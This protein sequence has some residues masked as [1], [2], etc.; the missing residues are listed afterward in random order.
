MLLMM[1]FSLTGASDRILGGRLGYGGAFEEGFRAMGTIALTIASVYAAS[2]LIGR[3]ISP[4]ASFLLAPFGI[5]S[6]ILPGLLLSSDMGAYTLALNMTEN[7]AA[8]A[9]SGLI[10]GGTVG[11]VWLFSIPVAFSIVEKDDAEYLVTGLLCGLVTLPLASLTGGLMMAFTPYRIG[12]SEI[13]S[14]TVPVAIISL[15][16]ALALHFIPG[17]AVC[18]FRFSAKLVTALLTLFLALAAFEE[19]TGIMLPA[20]SVMALKDEAGLTGL[21]RG[22]LVAGQVALVLSGAFPLV[23]FI[24]KHFSASLTKA[25]A[26]LGLN[27]SSAAGFIASAA[28]IIPMYSSYS[29]MDGKGKILNAAFAVSGAF[30]FGDHLAFTASVEPEMVLP[31]LCAKLTGGITAVALALLLSRPLL[32]RNGNTGS[33]TC[34][35]SVSNS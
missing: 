23:L 7:E 6:S 3:I 32:R 15:T 14:G 20:F 8:A 35:E 18:I 29:L 13:L 34:R 27:V 11:S 12:L 1:V 16:V 17:A 5:E 28:N 2:P 9:F 24:R 26:H 22:L 33:S 30:V 4:L 10:L 21:D 31:L 25:G 19:V